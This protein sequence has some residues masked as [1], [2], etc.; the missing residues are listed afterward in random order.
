MSTSRDKKDLK[1]PHFIPQATR[2]KTKPKVRRRKETTTITVEI[3]MK[4]TGKINEIKKCSFEEMIQMDKPLARIPEE[5]RTETE[6][7]ITEVLQ[8]SPQNYK[9]PQETTRNDH[10]PTNR[11]TYKN[12]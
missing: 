6:S 10:M 4:E 2:E 1:Q 12:G 9:G 8:W 5:K 3:K 11:T 7:E